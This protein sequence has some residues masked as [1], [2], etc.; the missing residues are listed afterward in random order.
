MGMRQNYNFPVVGGSNIQRAAASDSRLAINWYPFYDSVSDEWMQSFFA[1]SKAKVTFNVGVNPYYGRP[2]GLLALKDTAYAVSGNQVFQLD[3]TFAATVIGTINTVTGNVSMCAGSK[4]IMIVDGTGG[5]YYDVVAE[6]WQP[7]TDPDFPSAPTSCAEQQGYFLVNDS[8]TQSVYQCVEVGDPTKW[9]QFTRFQCNFE[10]SYLSYPVVSVYSINGRLFVFTLGFIQVYTNAGKA[11]VTF[12]E[13]KNLIFSYGALNQ[14]AI[15]KGTAGAQGEEAPQFLIF[16]SR[17]ADGTKKIMKT[18][19]NPPK[20][21]S[22]PSVDWRL[23]QL[24]HPED[25]VSFTWSENGQTFAHFNFVT[26][27]QTIVYNVT[28]DTFFDLSYNGKNRYFG[29]CFMNFQ[30]K[31][32]MSS[33]L[34]STLYEMSENYLSNNGIPIHRTLITE[35]FRA[36]GYPTLTG[37]WIEF[38]FQ[39]GVGLVGEIDPNNPNYVYGAEPAIYLYISYD[40]GQTFSEPMKSSLG[41]SGD[42]IFTT[43]FQG[44]LGAS[45]DWTFKLEVYV[46]VQIF[47]MGAYFNYTQGPGST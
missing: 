14:G 32:L 4:Y 37:H 7:I 24:T 28:N 44:G 30:D 6:D 8:G 2:G 20:V 34:D 3:N 25:V 29:Q 17:T 10:S 27:K 35:N 39:Q 33:Y 22:T 13:D 9:D 46:P 15:A 5:W 11:G 40:G 18:S 36:N 19:G 41:L 47:L 26:D 31:K 43:R 21:I 1:G 38:Y 42:R 16:I 23:N 12:R 45:K